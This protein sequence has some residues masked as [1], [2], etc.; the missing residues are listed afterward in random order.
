MLQTRLASVDKDNDEY[1]DVNKNIFQ[2]LIGDKLNAQCI[3][4]LPTSVGQSD[5]NKRC[6]FVAVIT[7]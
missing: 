2:R 3:I 4:L 1:H 6:S 7:V 5:G